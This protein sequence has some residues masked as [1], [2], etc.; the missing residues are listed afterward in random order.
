MPDLAV[1]TEG[2]GDREILFLMGFGCGLNQP[3]MIWAK[4]RIVNS[5]FRATFVE[6]PTHFE[7]FQADVIDPCLEIE[8][9][10]GDH[11]LIGFS[12]GG[13]AGSF[14]FG[15]R[16]RIFLCPFWGI[17]ETLHKG[18]TDFAL[19]NLRVIRFRMLPR[20][21]HHGDMGEFAVKED[22]EGLPEFLDFHSISEM[23]EKQLNLPPPRDGD[24][25]FWS[26]EDLLIGH[27]EILDR[28]VEQRLFDGGHMIYLVGDRESIFGEILDLADDEFKTQTD[29]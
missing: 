13:L 18:W 29:R 12:M 8:R 17:S 26:K 22:L 4:D 9:G 15:S 2:K 24:I 28:G 20:R 27:R 23:K 3:G 6:L 19:R 10:M 11:V 5:G 16:R 21:F 1:R 25:V 14:L 7:D